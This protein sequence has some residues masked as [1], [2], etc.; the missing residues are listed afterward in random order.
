VQSF[1]RGVGMVLAPGGV[2]VIYGPFRYGGRYTSESNREFDRALR[3][4]DPA[5]GLRDIEALNALA[6]SY[7]LTLR[8][9]HDL[10]AFN[11]LLVFG[12]EPG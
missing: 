5:S 2:L 3:E 10:P 6:A 9:D 7:G 1:Y 4:R 8:E 12:K 11:R